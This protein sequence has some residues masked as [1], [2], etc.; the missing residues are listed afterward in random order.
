[1]LWLYQRTM[2]GKLDKPENQALKDLNFRESLTLIPLVVLAFW[3]G[4]FPETFLGML[5]PSVRR[6][7]EQVSEAGVRSAS[8]GSLTPAP[9]GAPRP[10]RSALSSLPEPADD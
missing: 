8:S 3:I 1:M 6:L 4:I 7:V 9:S 5:R 10:A 2:F